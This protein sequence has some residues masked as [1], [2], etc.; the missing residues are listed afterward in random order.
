MAAG[1]ADTIRKVFGPSPILREGH[2]G[3][4]EVR[5]D[6]AVI[7]SNG[8]ECGRLPE[9]FEIHGALEGGGLK[10]LGE[11]PGRAGDPPIFRGLSCTLPSGSVTG[12]PGP[13]RVLPMTES[14][15]VCNGEGS[16]NE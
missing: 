1:L 9:P 13:G 12:R 15:S 16:G 3:V 5:L 10:P 14:G 6:G 7:Y 11:M 4:F 8:S 2:G